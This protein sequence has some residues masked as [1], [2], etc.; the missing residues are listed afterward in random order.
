MYKHARTSIPLHVNR[1][2]FT[3]SLSVHF[4]KTELTLNVS[5]HRPLYILGVFINYQK[6]TNSDRQSM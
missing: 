4:L 6:V 1:I 2:I 5:G 3:F